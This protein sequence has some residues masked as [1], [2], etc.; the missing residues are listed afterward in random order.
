MACLTVS[1]VDGTRPPHRPQGRRTEKDCL[2]QDGWEAASLLDTGRI[3]ELE[4]EGVAG[5]NI[6]WGEQRDRARQ[7]HPPV[8]GQLSLAATRCHAFRNVLKSRGGFEYVPLS[9][10]RSKALGKSRVSQQ[11]PCF[12]GQKYTSIRSSM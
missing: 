5:V 4:G 7:P 6:N 1:H 3:G 9:M 12:V 10:A 8:L 2:A 11:R